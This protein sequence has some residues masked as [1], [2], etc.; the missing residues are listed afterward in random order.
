MEADPL[1]MARVRRLVLSD[2]QLEGGD[3]LGR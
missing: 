2:A 1:R 3:D